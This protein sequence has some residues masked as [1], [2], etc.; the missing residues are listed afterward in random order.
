MEVLTFILSSHEENFDMLNRAEDKS[1]A[2][3]IANPRTSEFEVNFPPS[4]TPVL[5]AAIS[6]LSYVLSIDYS[7]KNSVNFWLI[8]VFLAKQKKLRVR[9]VTKLVEP[10]RIRLDS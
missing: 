8:D 5:G 3:I 7:A 4:P 9:R 2:V 6:Q 10:I 1:K